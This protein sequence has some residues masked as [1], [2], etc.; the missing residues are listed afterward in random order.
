MKRIP[1][2]LLVLL[3]GALPLSAAPQGKAS[4]ELFTRVEGDV[5]QLAIDIE[6][7]DGFHLY[8][9]ELGAPDAVGKP[10]SVTL[11]G[12]GLEFDELVWPE[13]HRYEQLGLGDD[14]GDTFILG[15]DQRLVI[16]G[17]AEMEAGANEE[18]LTV[19]LSG[20]TC[21]DGGS[22]FPYQETLQTS[23]QGKSSLWKKYPF[24]PAAATVEDSPAE[25]SSFGSS[26]FGNEEA[27][28]SD[29]NRAHGELFARA[30][31]GRLE[32]AI[33]I[34][35]DEG[36]HLYHK[37]LGGKNATGRPLEVEF[38]GDGME[39]GEPEWSEPHRYTQEDFFDGGETYI[40]GHEERLLIFGSGDLD[41]GADVAS[42]RVAL[43]GQTCEEG[44]MCY[45]Y[46]ET[47]AVGGPGAADLWA[48]RGGSKGTIH[49]VDAD[50]EDD[51]SD[52]EEIVGGTKEKGS[53]WTL[54]L[55]AIGGGIFALLMPC[56][57][58]MIPITI[59]FFTK[60]AEARG[61]NVLPLSLLYGLGIVL[62]FITIGLVVGPVILV[63]AT[64]PITNLV[65]GAMFVLF[66]AVLFGAITLNPPQS[67]MMLAGKASMRGGLLGV[68]LMGMTLVLT[69]FT[70][71][72]PFVG[73]LL[74]LAASGGSGIGRIALG[75]GVFGLTM[76]VPFMAL[77]L[78]PGKIQSLPSSGEW[79]DTLKISL[80][81]I[82]LAAALKFFSNT[83]LVWNWQVLS[84]E[85]F[86][87]LWTGIFVLAAVY[88]FGWIKIK[89][90]A[91]QEIGAGR[92][93]GAVAFLLFG[94]YCWHGYRGHT[95]DGI[96]TA[97]IPPYSSAMG[98]TAN[99]GHGGVPG[100]GTHEIVIDDFKAAKASAR[101]QY[102]PVLI[103]FTGFT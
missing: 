33:D 76:A 74:S 39:F 67:M 31:D 20:L 84:R 61:G 71:T 95:M 55:A 13:P 32:F 17:R 27:E 43:N 99:N 101:S 46:E 72:A 79:M 12:E 91:S 19:K 53:L 58:P 78:L 88:L 15:H 82:E 69:S 93:L 48:A 103:N 5:L 44:G 98:A 3:A 59:S 96:M 73:S 52:T 7:D 83:D 38:S 77:S 8:H 36:F 35:I 37:E 23:G 47:L 100:E 62:I 80:G 81:F 65:L 86:L 34:T 75:M 49:A 4:G 10:L 66:A 92:M 30:V 54:I 29:D 68:F 6:I 57:Y 97:I 60:Q 24:G 42:L 26:S 85:L 51:D 18:D 89:G 11:S 40:L 90:H 1:L 25:E 28:A 56:T 21:E 70:C 16:Y 9:H 22:C 2:S 14:G 50:P 41:E 94:A 63:F 87:L 64:H 102:K 45:L